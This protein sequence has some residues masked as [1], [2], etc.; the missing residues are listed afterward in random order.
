MF[1]QPPSTTPVAVVVDVV[2]ALAGVIAGFGMAAE[3]GEDVV[4]AALI[5]FVAALSSPLVGEIGSRSIDGLGDV[6]QM[7][8]GVEDVDDLDGAGGVLVRPVP[9][10]ERAVAEDRATRGLVEASSFGFAQSA[11][12]EGSGLVS[13][14]A[15]VAMAGHAQGRRRQGRP[16]RPSARSRGLKPAPQFSQ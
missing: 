13:R 14:L 1:L 9:Y 15:M 5:E 6:E 16:S 3:D 8:L 10:P 7:P 12:G 2:D 4:D 11:A